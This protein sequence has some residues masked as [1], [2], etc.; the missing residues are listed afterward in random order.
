M[1]VEYC[2]VERL[3]H[4]FRG[5]FS[6]AKAF[7]IRVYC[8]AQVPMHSEVDVL[9]VQHAILTQKFQFDL[10]ALRVRIKGQMLHAQRTA[11]HCVCFLFPF[12]SA[13]TQCQHVNNPH[14]RTQLCICAILGLVDLSGVITANFLNAGFQLDG[15]A[16][17]FH[18]TFPLEGRT[19]RQHD[20]LA[21]VLHILI[22]STQPSD[23]RIV[24]NRLPGV[25][26]LRADR[27]TGGLCQVNAHRLCMA[28]DFQLAR[29]GVLS[30]AA[31]QSWGLH[32]E[33]SHL[34]YS[35]VNQ[36]VAKLQQNLLSFGLLGSFL[37]FGSCFTKI[38][39]YI[40][41]FADLIEVALLE[42]SNHMIRPQNFLEIIKEVLFK[43]FLCLGVS[44]LGT[45]W[46]H[47]SKEGGQFLLST[48]EFHRLSIIIQRHAMGYI[49]WSK[50]DPRM[51]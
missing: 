11:P 4:I 26:G 31:E 25:S 33:V 16:V 7:Q 37:L 28:P 46:R 45:I 22:P 35:S 20:I 19:C 14:G 18:V 2:R 23:A 32:V 15:L 17:L 13:Y 34:L 1:L 6:L 43:D 50:I 38:L 47:G 12:L 44:Q 29:L 8:F 30:T 48:I 3:K 36:C 40:Q 24:L 27:H 51:L 9:L 41:I 5:F 42:L 49:R 21:L 10:V 39:L